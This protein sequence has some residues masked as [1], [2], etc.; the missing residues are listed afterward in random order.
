MPD[1][2]ITLTATVDRAD[3][4]DVDGLTGV[5][6]EDAVAD[7][8]EQDGEIGGVPLRNITVEGCDA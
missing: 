4:T 8:L 1:L 6:L 5:D 2:R 3:I 7:V